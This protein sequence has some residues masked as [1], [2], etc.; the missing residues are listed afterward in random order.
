MTILSVRHETNFLEGRVADGTIKDLQDSIRQL[1]DSLAFLEA[2]QNLIEEGKNI[3]KANREIG[4]DQ[5]GYQLE[6]LRSITD[7]FL[8]KMNTLETEKIVV[9][10]RM[11]K[12]L[13]RIEQFKDQ[14]KTWEN[15][16]ENR[17]GE[18]VIQIKSEEVQ[19]IDLSF[20]YVTDNAGWFPTYDL[21]A[22]TVSEPVYLTYKALA[23]Q[24]TGEDWK[25]VKLTFSNA[26]TETSGQWPDL[27]PW[28]LGYGR[29]ELSSILQTNNRKVEKVKG[30]IVNETGEPLIG[31]IILVRVT[32]IGIITDLDGEFELM[33]PKGATEIEI[34]YVGNNSQI[35][36]VDR[37]Q[38]N[39][40]LNVIET[41]LDEVVVT[42]YGVDGLQGRASGVAVMD[43]RPKK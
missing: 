36:P 17:S 9:K 40:Q 32:S 14:I 25:D 2:R 12:Q 41:A 22:T 35:I 5:N 26:K 38:I 7:F 8:E 18:V 30:K 16:Y 4:G 13:E 42:G 43:A 24:N 19:N 11:E 23:C 21:R 3:L 31:A 39:I 34:S 10:R 15:G 33:I 28:R 29:V 6:E 27:S 1:E 20:S 37:E